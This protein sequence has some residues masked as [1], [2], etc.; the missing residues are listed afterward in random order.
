MKAYCKLCFTLVLKDND[1]S[2]LHIVAVLGEL[3]GRFTQ[4]ENMKIISSASYVQVAYHFRYLIVQAAK[5][6]DL[7]A[8]N[9]SFIDGTLTFLDYSYYSLTAANPRQFADKEVKKCSQS[10]S[11]EL[12][13]PAGHSYHRTTSVDTTLITSSRSDKNHNN[14]P[15]VP[16]S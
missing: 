8:E 13:V 16:S 5:H 14:H 4:Q 6:S 10:A 12:V 15:A 2:C 7:T 11:A 1:N 9:V 3:Y